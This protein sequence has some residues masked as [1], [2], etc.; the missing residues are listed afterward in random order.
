MSSWPLWLPIPLRDSEGNLQCYSIEDLSSILL[1]NPGVQPELPE[2]D[3]GSAVCNLASKMGLNSR[4]LDIEWV[5]KFNDHPVKKQTQ[6]NDPEAYFK[7]S[8]EYLM[9]DP[10][11]LEGLLGIVSQ[12]PQTV[13]KD[14]YIIVLGLTDEE[15]EIDE[16]SE[17]EVEEE[18][19]K[20][21]AYIVIDIKR[22]RTSR[23]KKLIIP[24]TPALVGGELYGENLMWSIAS[25]IVKEAEIDDCWVAKDLVFDEIPQLYTHPYPEHLH[26]PLIYCLRKI[27]SARQGDFSKPPKETIGCESFCPKG[28]RF[29]DGTPPSLKQEFL[30]VLMPIPYLYDIII[31]DIELNLPLPNGFRSSIGDKDE[32][33]GISSTF[34][35]GVLHFNI[36][37]V[38]LYEK[39]LY[40]LRD[41]S[42]EQQQ[43]WQKDI[44][45]GTA[46]RLVRIAPISAFAFEDLSRVFHPQGL[47]QL[48]CCLALINE[49]PEEKS[50]NPKLLVAFHGNKT[51]S[52]RRLNLHLENL[53]DTRASSYSDGY[54]PNF[55]EFNERHWSLGNR[56]G[57]IQ[58]NNVTENSRTNNG[59]INETPMN[60]EGAMVAEIIHQSINDSRFPVFNALLRKSPNLEYHTDR[61]TFRDELEELGFD[62]IEPDQDENIRTII[63]YLPQTLTY[64]G[65]SI[66]A[67]RSGIES[68]I[69][70]QP[71]LCNSCLCQLTEAIVLSAGDN[72]NKQDL[73]DDRTVS[74][75]QSIEQLS[76]L[77]TDSGY[78]FSEE[79]QDIVA[80]TSKVETQFISIEDELRQATTLK[81][82]L[83][84]LERNT[85]HHSREGPGFRNRRSVQS[86]YQWFRIDTD[87]GFPVLWADEEGQTSHGIE[88][89]DKS[90]RLYR[91]GQVHWSI[92]TERFEHGCQGKDLLGALN[93]SFKTLMDEAYN[94]IFTASYDEDSIEKPPSFEELRRWVF[95]GA[96]AWYKNLENITP[97]DKKLEDFLR[98]VAKAL[99][100]DRHEA[101]DS[102]EMFPNRE[103]PFVTG[104]RGWS[105]EFAQGSRPKLVIRSGKI[106]TQQNLIGK[107]HWIRELFQWYTEQT[108]PVE[109]ILS[110]A[111]FNE[112]L[113]SVEDQSS[114]LDEVLGRI[115]LQSIENCVQQNWNELIEDD[116]ELRQYLDTQD[117][118]NPPIETCSSII[119]AISE[120]YSAGE[121]PAVTDPDLSQLYPFDDHPCMIPSYRGPSPSRHNRQKLRLFRSDASISLSPVIRNIAEFDDRW[122]E[123]VGNTLYLSPTAERAGILQNGWRLVCPNGEGTFENYIQNHWDNIFADH[124]DC[125]YVSLQGVVRFN[126]EG[127]IPE[128]NDNLIVH[129][130]HILYIVSLISTL[131]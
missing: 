91:I 43:Q 114:L 12:T 103:S 82:A 49:I 5:Q 42:N 52:P 9:K 130:L 36:S 131:S 67:F 57:F 58:P 95:S 94:M 77:F 2:D 92:I 105:F 14:R 102:N 71:D 113:E 61:D 121:V 20:T 51:S 66:D 125:E 28:F 17:E 93:N 112:K 63:E 122:L 84:K 3:F 86:N 72:I 81:I 97:T 33:S 16:I 89:I 39:R 4:S 23:K 19:E 128:Q 32:I 80:L 34:V 26:R 37:S 108:A 111:R 8:F 69:A 85:R 59:R 106:T 101:N 47:V 21:P 44:A 70:D 68:L 54:N 78:E 76:D 10:N 62:V 104:S 22:L 123:S 96:I 117:W 74:I 109:L 129:K 41:S 29:I 90:T 31:P 38:S 35:S 87:S 27:Q 126:N 124:Q 60:R 53:V 65:K 88:F 118:T 30:E 55:V 120:N 79:Y 50:D 56:V 45:E 98:D 99:D 24:R 64:H 1:L 73:G 83:N 75:L 11:R 48:L 46:A 25:S 100:V 116:Q 18:L 127:P 15:D 6:E 13:L 7:Y 119:A 40:D 107:M 115:R 110:R